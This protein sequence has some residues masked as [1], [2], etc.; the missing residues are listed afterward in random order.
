M[1][2]HTWMA[3]NSVLNDIRFQYA[4]AAYQIAPT[5]KEIFKEVGVYP[6]ER[7]GPDRVQRRLQFPSL[8]YGGNYEA[9]GPEE[10]TQVKDTLD[11]HVPGKMGSH[12]LKSGFDYSYITFA[13]D[14]QVNLN[15]TYQFG[16]DQFFDPNDPAN[17]ANLKNPILFTMT[18]PPYY[19]PLPT[20][21]F[22]LFVQ[23]DW[24]PVSKLTINAGLRYD[25]QIGSFNENINTDRFKIPIPFI[26]TSTRGDKNNFGPRLGFAYDIRGNGATVLRGGYGRY[27]DNIRTLQNQYQ[28]LN[29]QRY[30]IRITN[31]AYPTRSAAGARSTSRPLRH[32]TSR[33][34]LTTSRTRSRTPGTSGRLTS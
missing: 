30:D 2:S 18:T 3:T 19:V 16:T 17:V 13:D 22:A 9:L 27:Y 5:G 1:A 26:D 33:S 12:D 20:H 28:W 14:S 23:D 25:R 7:V 11:W 32:R 8:I 21:H 29:M 10:R 15:G 24:R 6:P 34:S 4:T 31:P